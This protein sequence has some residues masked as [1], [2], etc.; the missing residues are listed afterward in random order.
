MKVFLDSISHAFEA[1]GL[2]PVLGAFIV[3]V[4]LTFIFA[5]RRKDHDDRQLPGLSSASLPVGVSF[6][7]EITH[8]GDMSLTIDGRTVQVP[9]Q[10]LT[11]IAAGNKVEAI[12]ALRAA[13][14][15]DLKAAKQIVDKLAAAP[16]MR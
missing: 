7:K 10:V 9:P 14:G 12:K 6:K 2:H 3:G 8:T 15:L 11:H 1:M 13:A 5:R 4:V 16:I